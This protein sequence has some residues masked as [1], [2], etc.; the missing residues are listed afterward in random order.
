MECSAHQTKRLKLGFLAIAAIALIVFCPSLSHMPRGDLLGYLTQTRNHDDLYS[1][2]TRFYSFPRTIECS[3]QDA[4]DLRADK[5]LFRP[6]MYIWLG[7]EKRCFGPSLILWQFSGILIHLWC[8]WLILNLLLKIRVSVFAPL[9]VLFLAVLFISHEMVIWTNVHAYALAFTSIFAA[10]LQA[11]SHACEGQTRAWRLWIMGICLTLA[12]FAY[13]LT[14]PTGLFIAA[15]LMAVHPETAT[16]NAPLTFRPGTAS[17]SKAWSLCLLLPMLLYTVADR[18]D[19]MVHEGLSPGLTLLARLDPLQ[20][21]NNAVRI[22]TKLF[23]AG[24]LPQLEN[25]RFM[26]NRQVWYPCWGWDGSP[27]V[28]QLLLLG[29]LLVVLGAGVR[30][31]LSRVQTVEQ[32]RTARLL[33]AFLGMLIGLLGTTTLIIVGGRVSDRGIEYLQK[34]LYYT[35]PLWAFGVTI[36]YTM[37]HIITLYAPAPRAVRILKPVLMVLIAGLSAVNAGRV[38]MADAEIAHQFRRQREFLERCDRF[39]AQHRNDPDF[40]FRFLSSS[41]DDGR[42]LGSSKPGDS[43]DGYYRLSEILYARYMRS[44]KPTVLVRDN[45]RELVV[46]DPPGGK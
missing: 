13:E 38:F 33:M 29:L 31:S 36:L 18:L 17:L 7:L 3:H 1:L 26:G 28:F 16:K 23:Y 43:G 24:I 14:V 44:D 30:H 10:I 20:I 27:Y 45:G 21:L 46:M 15:F 5:F 9:S 22:L 34:S 6:L 40:S 12:C 41:S 35:Y 19:R 2:T 32:G 11:Y 4:A 8:L 39:V 42:I 25:V 37:G